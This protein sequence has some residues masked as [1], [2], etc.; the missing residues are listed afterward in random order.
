MSTKDPLPPPLL[1]QGMHHRAPKQESY[2]KQLLYY[3]FLLSIVRSVKGEGHEV[4][5]KAP[6]HLQSDNSKTKCILSSLALLKLITGTHVLY[7]SLVNTESTHHQL[8]S[9]RNR[10]QKPL[11]GTLAYLLSDI[12]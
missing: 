6:P 11:F 12:V 3:V 4:K 10:Q 5:E 2:P 7:S 8:K 1:L 9:I